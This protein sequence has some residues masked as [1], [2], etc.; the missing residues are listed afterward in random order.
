MQTC[1][2]RVWFANATRWNGTLPQVTGSG[3]LPMINLPMQQQSS[4]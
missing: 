2:E 3:A 1:A 4:K